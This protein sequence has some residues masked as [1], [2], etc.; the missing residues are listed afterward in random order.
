MCLSSEYWDLGYLK[1]YESLIFGVDFLVNRSILSCGITS[2]VENLYA[3]HSWSRKEAIFQ[4]KFKFQAEILERVP[5]LFFSGPTARH[6]AWPVWVAVTCVII[7]C[8]R[9]AW[10]L[11]EILTQAS[12]SQNLLTWLFSVADTPNRAWLPASR[13]PAGL[14]SIH[15]RCSKSVQPNALVGSFKYSSLL[16]R[17]VVLLNRLLRSWA[18][19]SLVQIFGSQSWQWVKITWGPFK[20]LDAQATP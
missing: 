11:S 15:G 8:D 5:L 19:A 2:Y 20:S 18:G 17:R 6:T 14:V 9:N 16:G 10:L 4:E 13:I 7:G 1:I 3:W 12:V